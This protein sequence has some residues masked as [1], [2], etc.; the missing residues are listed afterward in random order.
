MLC[1]SYFLAMWQPENYPELDAEALRYCSYVLTSIQG[2]GPPQAVLP[3]A[4]GPASMYTH[5]STQVFVLIGARIDVNMELFYKLIPAE[6]H[7]LAFPMANKI[8]SAQPLS[9]K[10]MCFIQAVF[11]EK[12]LV[13]VAAMIVRSAQLPVYFH[14]L[15]QYT[16]VSVRDK[17]QQIASHGIPLLHGWSEDLICTNLGLG[18]FLGTHNPEKIVFS[19]REVVRLIEVK[20]YDRLL[21]VRDLSLTEK[22]AF[23]SARIALNV[24]L[25][26]EESG[27]WDRCPEHAHRLYNS[28]YAAQKFGFAS[29]EA[30]LNIHRGCACAHFLVNELA[31]RITTPRLVHIMPPPEKVIE[32]L[33]E[34][35]G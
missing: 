29:N 24:K 31:S 15:V 26:P 11:A 27:I 25:S 9:Y 7:D 13:E 1:L 33:P 3:P 4:H 21:E 30:V 28:S 2:M 12:Q 16:C 14:K 23:A 5:L 19:Q 22:F 34:P 32:V 8:D 35:D 18:V 20:Y 17:E 10:S 6:F